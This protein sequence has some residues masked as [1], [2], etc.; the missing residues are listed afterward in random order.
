MP[1]L[2]LAIRGGTVVTA[3]DTMRADVGVRGGRIVALAERVEGAAREIDASGLLVLPGGID[4]HVHVSQPSGP[5]IVMA[6]DFASATAAAAAGGNTCIMPFALQARGQSLRAVVED[7]VGQADGECYVDVGF[8]LIVSDP[9]PE[10]LGQELPALLKAGYTSFKVFMTYDDL[11]LSDRQLL[12]VFDVARREGALV[13]V[14]AEGYDAIRFMTERLER[15]GRTAPYYH[16]VSR[17]EIVERKA[18]HRAI[19]HAELVDVPIMIVHVSGREATE[20]IRW[21]RQRGLKV[22]AETCP[23]YMT[24]TADDL[25]GVDMD[26]NGAKYVC[27]PPP[28]DAASQAAI[29]EGLHQGVFDVVSSDHCP[30]RYDDPAGK[31]APRGRS[32]FRWVPN[33]I[34]GVETRLPILF[35]EGVSK[36]R[37]D[38]QR[39]VALTSTNHARIYGLYPRKGSIAVGFDADVAL[40]DPNRKETIRQEILH[41]GAD[42]T[43]WEGFEVTGWPVMTLVRGEVV[44][45]DGRIVGTKGSGRAIDAEARRRG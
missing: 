25:Q 34:P 38:L 9:T 26:M 8:H 23:Q 3:S 37:I 43:P 27:S 19:S 6:D 28:R 42:Y 10:V 15:E 13:M 2:D 29:W 5:G 14:H 33:G 36:G 17:P 30:F 35:S 44:A 21:A 40:W 31:L 41:H 1:D 18:T 16:A 20:Q 4:S 22:F 45:Q 32:S 24:L 12:D 11:V 39:F 7:Y